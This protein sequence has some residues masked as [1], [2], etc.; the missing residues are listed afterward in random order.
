M[1]GMLPPPR[2]AARPSPADSYAPSSYD[3]ASKTM[4][5]PPK[6][7]GPPVVARRPVSGPPSSSAAAAA[8]E[9]RPAESAPAAPPSSSS[10]G[11]GGGDGTAHAPPSSKLEALKAAIEQKKRAAEAGASTTATS[12]AASGG[13]GSTG[14]CVVVVGGGGSGDPAAGGSRSRPSERERVPPLLSNYAVPSWSALPRH[15]FHLEVLKSGTIIDD[16]PLTAAHATVGR[17]PLV[18]LP[19]ENPSVSR[20]H[21]VFQFS[22]D[23]GCYLFDLG[24]V[25]GTFVNKERCVCACARVRSPRARALCHARQQIHSRWC[26]R[27]N[28]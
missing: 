21:A 24:S 3:A 26:P 4:A 16:I 13:G 15:D 2:P 23:G 19:M 1:P 17:H 6:T 5:P 11:G 20:Q 9:Q 7:M 28:E 8:A 18:E 12:A 27:M 25:H 22:E 14:S 10:S